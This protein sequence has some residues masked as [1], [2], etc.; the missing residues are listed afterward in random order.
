MHV[1]MNDECVRV[2][3]RGRVSVRV[4]GSVRV[5]AGARVYVSLYVRK[6]SPGERR[7]AW[8]L[9]HHRMFNQY[10]DLQVYI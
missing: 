3:V 10:I 8:G 5:R 7:G 2:N 9:H 4:C 1:C 6:R